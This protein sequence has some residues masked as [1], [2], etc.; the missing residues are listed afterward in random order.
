MFVSFLKQIYPELSFHNMN[1]LNLISGLDN[2]KNKP[3]IPSLVK[4]ETWNP[5]FRLRPE[6][7]EFINSARS[8]L[9]PDLKKGEIAVFINEGN[10]CFH[11]ISSAGDKTIHV[12]CGETQ[13]SENL[14]AWALTDL[15]R[16]LGR[17]V[18]RGSYELTELDI[19]EDAEVREKAVALFIS[20]KLKKKKAHNIQKR[21][22][23]Y[24]GLVKALTRFQINPKLLWN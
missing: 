24:G 1:N 15:M 17:P 21:I 10:S 14:L 22:K 4:E 8:T 3:T 20:T 11:G 7:S 12:R 19:D 5:A 6:Y 18:T 23:K 13:F 2:E 16:T 9:Q